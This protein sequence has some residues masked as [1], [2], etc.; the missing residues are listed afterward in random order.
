MVSSGSVKAQL[1]QMLKQSFA[2]MREKKFDEAKAVLLE[3]IALAE[4]EE[5]PNS[6]SLIPLLHHL[7]GAIEHEGDQRSNES[8]SLHQRALAIAETACGPE[9]LETAQ[10]LNEMSTHLGLRDRYEDLVPLRRRAMAIY[11]LRDDLEGLNRTRFA[12]GEALMKLGQSTEAVP[13]LT[14]AADYE[15]AAGSTPHHRLLARNS[16][17]RA[18]I[19]EGRFEEARRNLELAIEIAKTIPRY[20]DESPMAQ[21]LRELMNQ[22]L[23]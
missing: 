14:M 5:G 10:E 12:L 8:L 7:G 15:E 9:S 18:L 3:A 6:A 2:L 4:A 19:A 22:M 23:N 17:S 1:Q 16:L 13:L 21:G 11:E 20:T